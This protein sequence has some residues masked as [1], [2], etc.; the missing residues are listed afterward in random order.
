MPSI[1]A[2][3]RIDRNQRFHR[4]R[5]LHGASAPAPNLHQLD[6]RDQIGPV[7]GSGEHCDFIWTPT[8]TD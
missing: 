1:A 3:S 2:C 5:C 4:R 7:E 6:G 8:S